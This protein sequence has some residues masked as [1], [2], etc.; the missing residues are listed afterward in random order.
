MD[1]RAF[2]KYR[3][4][5]LTFWWVMAVILPWR[6]PGAT[7]QSLLRAAEKLPVAEEDERWLRRKPEIEKLL[8]S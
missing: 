5:L 1:A 3:L 6:G 8:P 4:P 2:R 7:D